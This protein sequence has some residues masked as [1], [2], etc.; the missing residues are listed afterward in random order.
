[1]SLRISVAAADPAR[2]EQAADLAAR[3]ALPVVALHDAQDFEF[4]LA[5]T[6]D[7]LELR[8][9]GNPFTTGVRAD[10][11]SIDVR[12]GSRNLSKKQPLA[13]AIGRESRRVLDATAGLGHDAFLLAAMGY[14]VTALERS[15][16]VASLLSDGV[17]RALTEPHLREAIDDRL[18]VVQADARTFMRDL[19]DVPDVIYLDPMF[20]PRRK[21]SALA[22]KS[23]RL[24]RTVVGEDADAKEL[25][26]A[27]LASGARRVV[28]KRPTDARAD[29]GAA[30]LII[31][32][33]LVR[34]EVFFP[35]TS[36]TG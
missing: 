2:A 36:A 13:R 14:E 24:I 9:A 6:H 4:V 34:Y 22:R 5:V 10:F 33:R 16:V 12:R 7:G 35:M 23:I 1:M 20:P 32:A 21:A 25:L 19:T 26:Q 29:L 28:L 27:A 17:Q 31:P 8:E 30:S 3:L 18:C 11:R 15:A